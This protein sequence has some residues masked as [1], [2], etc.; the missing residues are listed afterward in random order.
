[1]RAGVRAVTK[2]GAPE[3]HPFDEA[4]QRVRQ[5]IA[6]LGLEE[7]D[8]DVA[9]DRVLAEPVRA[10][11]RLPPFTNS[12]VDGWAVRAADI[13]AA[14]PG[15]PVR[16]AIVAHSVAGRAAG[17]RVGPGEAVRIMTGGPMPDGA[18]A[19]VMQ[20]HAEWDE[21]HVHIREAARPGHHVRPAGEEAEVGDEVLAP[22]RPLT[23]A[24]VGMLA[25]LGVPRVRVHM[26]PRVD[27]LATGDELLEAHD[28]LAPGKIRSSNDR[29]LVGQVR[30]AGAIARRMA[31]AADDLDVLV[32][33]IEAARAADVLVTSGGVSV[34]DR[35]FLD[36]ALTRLGFRRIF[37]RVASSPGK[38]LL[39]GRL[40]GTLVF[41]L[42]GNPVSS[43][44]AFENFVRPALRMLQ[45]DVQPER[46]R[47]IARA[48][49]AISGPRNRRHFARVRLAHD[50]S[51]WIAREVGPKGSGNL[52]SMA[53][54]NALA[55][56]PEGL[57]RVEAGERVEVMLLGMPDFGKAPRGG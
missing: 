23:P 22:G 53:D 51:D 18:D 6:P 52:R 15:N 12:A 7:V 16:L 3:P 38:P 31:L 36:A 26:R 56:V 41:G 30:A 49:A 46:P 20:E 14:S 37:W 19:L 1:M 47:T 11:H 32:E 8:L 40:G 55:I 25:S 44:V 13:A 10:T 27:V 29:T 39:F 9:Y 48:A 45:G 42:P 28:A 2:T 35:D 33:R 43:M 17:V 5:E 4:K 57:D 50:G 54:A 34:G 21:R 24:A